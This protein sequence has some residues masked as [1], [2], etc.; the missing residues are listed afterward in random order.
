MSVRDAAAGSCPRTFRTQHRCAAALP[1]SSLTAPSRS[2]LFTPPLHT[3]SVP[4]SASF[5]TTF[6]GALPRRAAPDLPLL[7]GLPSSPA[8][9]LRRASSSFSCANLAPGL[10][11]ADT[12]LPLPALLPPT[13]LLLAPLLRIGDTGGSTSTTGDDDADA[14]GGTGADAAD[15]ARLSVCED[16]REERGGS[17]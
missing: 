2:H 9:D 8:T 5:H 11:P 10:V 6:F 13:L 3:F 12:L 1:P 14:D 7:L 16:A 4:S 17:G 15:A